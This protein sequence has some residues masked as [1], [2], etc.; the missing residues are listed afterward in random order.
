MPR[1]EWKGGSTIGRLLQVVP[2]SA[3]L[4]VGAMVSNAY[5]EIA[6]EIPEEVD[7]LL[8]EPCDCPTGSRAFASP[9]QAS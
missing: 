1:C 3:R 4:T 2:D 5:D 9:P 7:Y 8:H 6:D